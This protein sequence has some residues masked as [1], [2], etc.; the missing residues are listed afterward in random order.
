M[1]L[2]CYTQYVSTALK[3]GKLYTDHRTGKVSFQSNPKELYIVTLLI[4]LICRVHHA[5]CPAG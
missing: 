2:K 5:K 3:F 1:L 4:Q